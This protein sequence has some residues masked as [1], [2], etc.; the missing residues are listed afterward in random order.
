MR[1]TLSK[2]ALAFLQAGADP[3]LVPRSSDTV[4][5]VR[6]QTRAEN[7]P[8]GERAAAHHRVTLQEADVGGVPCLR[9]TP[10]N[11]L[12]DF[13][14]VYLFGGGFI[15]GSAREDLPIS[16]ALAAKTKR[17]VVAV[18]YELSPEAP[19]PTAVMQAFDAYRALA[20]QGPVCLAGESAGGNLAL[21]TLLKADAEAVPLPAAVVLLSPWCDLTNTGDSLFS[22]DGRDPTL[23]RHNVV[24]AAKLYG[25][26]LTSPHVSP[27]FGE[28]SSHFPPTL[29][30]SGTRD[31]LLSPSV[32][33][34]HV[35]RNA[36]VSVDLR[37]WE[38]MWHVF[39][40]YAEI[41]EGIASLDECADFLNT[42]MSR[43][44][45]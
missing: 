18:E 36:G 28:Y 9:V 30:T 24:E 14:I 2:E 13:K 27:L 29:I 8:A 5:E 35:L 41:P 15:T 10:P 22:N 44:K 21:V 17:E 11:P 26:N 3:T 19:W 25:G 32:Q 23:T 1:N 42:H 40:F 31:L 16:A 7:L 43:T 12:D 38:G 39:E 37:V 6:A 33:I 20:A 45:S 34:A 4:Q